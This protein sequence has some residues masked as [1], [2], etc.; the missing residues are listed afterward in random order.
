MEAL[1][2]VKITKVVN[3]LSGHCFW[4]EMSTKQKEYQLQVP[5]K[6]NVEEVFNVDFVFCE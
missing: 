5:F 4:V 2:S 3:N 6:L 1:G